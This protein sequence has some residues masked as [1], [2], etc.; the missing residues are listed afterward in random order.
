MICAAQS[1]HCSHF[2]M[3]FSTS[4]LL[5]CHLL[6]GSPSLLSPTAR[7]AGP[8]GCCMP[9]SA[10]VP[11]VGQQWQARPQPQGLEPGSG[12][13]RRERLTLWQPVGVGSLRAREKTGHT[14]IRM[15]CVSACVSRLAWVPA[16]PWG[17]G[18]LH[19]LRLP[20]QG[21]QRREEKRASAVWRNVCECVR[22]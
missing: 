22:Q 8:P 16:R 9:T 20:S 12:G 2:L 15:Q 17:A 1:P 18:V 21:G 11:I 13:G 7:S 3:F 4:N 14:Q 5:L 19:M 6:P 10:R